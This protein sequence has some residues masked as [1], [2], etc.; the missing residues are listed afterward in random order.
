MVIRHRARAASVERSSL[1]VNITLDD[2]T[3]AQADMCF[4]GLGRLPNTEKL[5]LSA[6]GI[7]LDR[8]GTV[9]V[10]QFQ[11]TNIP[12]IYA[13]GDVVGFPSLASVSMEQGRVAAAHMFGEERGALNTL[14]E[15]TQSLR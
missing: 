10:D 3:L 6:A 1:G 11:R 7:E 2:G 8:R 12:H 15:S 14:M 13:A 5:D 9:K 4:L